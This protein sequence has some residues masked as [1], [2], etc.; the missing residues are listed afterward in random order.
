MELGVEIRKQL[1]EAAE[2]D[3]LASWMA[4]YLGEK[5]AGAKRARGQQREELKKECAELI[6]KLWHHRHQLPNGGRPLQSFE[7][8]FTALKELS[9]DEPRYSFL[10]ELP[11]SDPR[12]EAGKVIQ[13]ILSIDSAANALIR[14]LLA[15]AVSKMPKR[16][17]RWAAI[18]A[19]CE[20]PSFDIKIVH[21]LVDEAESLSDMQAKLG[22]AQQDKLNKM[23]SDLEYFD[24]STATL[25]AL[26]ERKLKENESP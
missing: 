11:A 9:Q 14:Y 2:D 10:R 8:L 13:S 12:S 1:G 15:E 3:L 7:P 22:K 17:K 25:R 16:D 24:K 23:L 18:Q 5:L 20:P 19:A 26:L 4:E 21:A 6:L